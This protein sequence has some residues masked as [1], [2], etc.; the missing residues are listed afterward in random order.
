MIRS[1]RIRTP[2]GLQKGIGYRGRRFAKFRALGLRGFQFRVKDSRVRV[3]GY[4]I[5][6]LL[7]D[8]DAIKGFRLL[9]TIWIPGML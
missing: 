5:G 7:H 1:F 9:L 3:R 4:C 2:S 8:S 6:V